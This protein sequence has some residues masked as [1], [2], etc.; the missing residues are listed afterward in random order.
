MFRKLSD[1]FLL[2]VGSTGILK[3][4]KNH[5]VVPKTKRH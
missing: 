5:L 4:L 3:T 1:K 2:S